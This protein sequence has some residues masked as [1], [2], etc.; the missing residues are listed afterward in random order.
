MDSQIKM[1]IGLIIIIII[2][3]ACAMLVY[4]FYHKKSKQVYGQVRPVVS[5]NQVNYSIGDDINTNTNPLKVELQAI[6]DDYNR[7]DKNDP[8]YSFYQE[9]IIQ[10]LVSLKNKIA[11]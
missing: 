5:T 6:V 8:N 10:R 3:N 9:A 4:S 1:I 2:A 7:L 11:Q